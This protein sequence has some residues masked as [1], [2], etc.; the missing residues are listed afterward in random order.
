[1]TMNFEEYLAKYPPRAPAKPSSD[2]DEDRLLGSADG[3]N[4]LGPPPPV[5]THRARP[6]KKGD[7]GCHLWVFDTAGVPYILERASVTPALKA[8][9]VKHS[10]LT[11]GG[12]AACGG[13]IW[14]D[15]AADDDIIINGC[16]GRYGP[17]TPSE[18][19]AAEEVFKSFGYTVHSFGW[20]F[21]ANRPAMVFEA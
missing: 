18:L 14:F 6:A 21:D 3:V 2:P 10:N 12:P 7:P 5:T 15:P 11:G 8:G 16:S 4:R 20:S 13:E 17:R 9:A 19:Q 1:M